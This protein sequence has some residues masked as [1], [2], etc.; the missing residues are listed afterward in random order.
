[1]RNRLKCA[2]G[3]FKAPAHGKSAVFVIFH[4]NI[5]SLNILQKH[6]YAFSFIQGKIDL[7]VFEMLCC[8]YIQSM[9]AK[10]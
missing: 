3:F 4:P 10:T 5:L 1:M 8:R 9:I 7:Y 2:K 6:K